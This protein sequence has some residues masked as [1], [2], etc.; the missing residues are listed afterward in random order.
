MTPK[1]LLRHKRAVSTLEEMSGDIDVPPHCSGTMR[2][3]A[4]ERRSSWSR[5]NKIRRVVMC[6]GKVYYDLLRR[7]REARH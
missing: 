7:A 5:T 3:T 2:N 1:S 4:Q 6:S